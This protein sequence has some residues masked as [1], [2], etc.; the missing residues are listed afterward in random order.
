MS[1]GRAPAA[2]VDDAIRRMRDAAAAGGHD[3][4]P[5]APGTVDPDVLRT[6]LATLPH[7][8]QRLLW[9][10][11][12][13]GR[14]LATIAAEIGV[15]A[16]ALRRR[17][18]HAE[19]RLAAAFADA[20]ARACPPGCL[21]TRTSLREYV[22]HRLAPRRR[23]VL[24]EHLFGCDGCM[25]A[26][27]DVRQASW[28]LR[29]AGPLLLG[30][31]SAATAGPVVVGAMTAASTGAGLAGLGSVGAALAAAWEWLRGQV[32][33][34]DRLGKAGLAGA[35]VVA[36]VAVTAVAVP[37]VGGGPKP[38]A[39]AA[40][41]PSSADPAPPVE[42]PGDP[43]ADPADDEP[44][45]PPIAPPADPA[46]VDPSPVDPTPVDP[47]PVD[48]APSDP[49]GPS[50]GPTT[51]RPEPVPPS[52]PPSGTPDPSDDPAD[53]PTARPTSPE[54]TP[55]PTSPTPSPTTPAPTPTPT[56]TEPATRTVS[57][58]VPES[59]IARV[60]E[61]VAVG[62]DAQVV[63]VRSA[64][65]DT[66]QWPGF[67]T[68]YVGSWGRDEATVTVEL[69]GA[70]GSRPSATLKQLGRWNDA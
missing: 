60:Y 66:T 1:E 48:P 50:D 8:D 42:V 65:G 2:D 62:E 16:R 33:R 56:P 69:E 4:G 34:L 61:V 46:P 57:L 11:H 3:D 70:P 59:R 64:D 37:L 15:H 10:H 27:I 13:R 35:G 68:W 52:T 38:E 9:S 6:V 23:T 58:T 19:Q 40:A 24:E 32:L 5:G 26:F 21:D 51:D 36:V 39:P 55:T 45:D 17:L 20:H 30:G 28:A 7:D 43:T 53:E 12:V 49:A 41:P 63:G 14:S 31:L 18:H 44:S 54:P 47:S 22:S 67:R 29:D 25:R